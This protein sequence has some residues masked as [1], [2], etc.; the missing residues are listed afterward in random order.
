MYPKNQWQRNV[1]LHQYSIYNLP[2]IWT[3]IFIWNVIKYK[4][5]WTKKTL[6]S[7][8]YPYY[9][10]PRLMLF[11]NYKHVSSFQIQHK[12]ELTQPYY[13][14]RNICESYDSSIAFTLPYII[15]IFLY[16]QEYPIW[17][18]RYFSISIHHNDIITRIYKS[19]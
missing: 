13:L 12:G 2:K 10:L 14:I 17:I 9:Y 7:Y 3:L 4:K 8:D 11:H 5:H 15:G 16:L 19:T 6:T 18:G 1:C